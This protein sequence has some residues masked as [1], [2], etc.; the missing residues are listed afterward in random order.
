MLDN[1][2]V[3]ITLRGNSMATKAIEAYQKL[4]G[5]NFLEKML[6]QP[7]KQLINSSNITSSPG[8]QTSAALTVDMADFEVDPTRL[9]SRMG[10]ST[11]LSSSGNAQVLPN[12]Y[13]VYVFQAFHASNSYRLLRHSVPSIAIGKLY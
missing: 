11:E 1:E 3:S 7:I 10:S 6:S 13:I 12:C 8:A 9:T 2:N 4:V 5:E